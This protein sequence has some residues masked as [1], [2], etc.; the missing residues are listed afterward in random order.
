VTSSHGRHR[1][2]HGVLCGL[3]ATYC[4]LQFYD[5]I[6]L[7]NCKLNATKSAEWTRRT[8]GVSSQ[9]FVRCCAP[10]K[11]NQNSTVA[12][13]RALVEIS[14]RRG[15]YPASY[16]MGTRGSSLGVKRPGRKTDQ[17]PPSSAKVKECLELYI[18]FPN[19]PSWRGA[20]FKTKHRDNFTFYLTVMSARKI[21]SEE[22]MEFNFF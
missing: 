19:T 13:L 21:Y 12:L 4:M 9:W 11:T 14:V 5:T 20:Q 15:L 18:H 6:F 17:S 8:E 3:R 1:E 22:F 10:H 16:P 2:F 7:W